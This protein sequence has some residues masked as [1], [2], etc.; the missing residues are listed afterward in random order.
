MEGEGDAPAVWSRPPH[1][2]VT[3]TADG[4]KVVEE[5]NSTIRRAAWR[6]G[7]A[8]LLALLASPAAWATL[9]FDDLVRLVSAG[10]SEETILDLADVEGASFDLTVEQIIELKEV[11]A[12]EEFIRALMATAEVQGDER[13][14][15]RG[16]AYD[17]DPEDVYDDDVLEDYSTVFLY[18]YYDPF[19]YYWY[20][21]PSYYVYYSP[22]WWSRAGFYY[23][24]AWSWDWW[25]PWS[26]SSWYCH[27]HYGY[28]HWFGPPRT[29][30][31]GER[32]WHRMRTGFSDRAE[33]ER[34]VWQ[35]AG[36]V[37]PAGITARAN[38]TWRDAARVRT[39]ALSG[40]TR[41]EYRTRRIRG[42]SSSSSGPA[43]RDRGANRRTPGTEQGI[44]RER[45]A[46]RP[47]PQRQGSTRSSRSIRSGEN[48]PSGRT[49]R[50]NGASP[51]AAPPSGD[52]R[53][54]RARPGRGR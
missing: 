15:D 26:P 49:S 27:D 2:L 29:R 51:P 22:F 45:S 40:T 41:T 11:G 14:Y 17:D 9:T 19:A 4:R 46:P 7:L 32:D 18:H 31:H 12:S 35:R 20:A 36:L 33:R 53:S 50:G 42:E 30:P 8:L 54:E 16:D 25:D 48:Q 3:G 39:R 10:V 1:G 38:P 24:G 28:Q 23:G 34:A 21:W 52:S 13:L 44:R 37:R 47:V 5:M 43:Y 6:A